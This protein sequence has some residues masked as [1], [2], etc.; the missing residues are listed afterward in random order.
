MPTFCLR[1]SIYFNNYFIFVTVLR[2]PLWT[3][4]ILSSDDRLRDRAAVEFE[5]CLYLRFFVLEGA[6]FC[7]TD[8][9]TL[10]PRSGSKYF[11]VCSCRV[12]NVPK[13]LTALKDKRLKEADEYSIVGIMNQSNILPLKIDHQYER[14]YNG[15]Y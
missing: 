7:A 9:G 13:T 6:P 8:T 4:L 15:S 12:L 11:Q 14:Q 2:N 3:A 1:M 10:G 5:K